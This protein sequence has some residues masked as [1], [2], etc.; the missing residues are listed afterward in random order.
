MSMTFVLS[1]AAYGY[2]FYKSDDIA[3]QRI[4]DFEE[5]SGMSYSE[6]RMKNVPQEEFSQ[7]Y[8]TLG[9]TIRLDRA[10]EEN[11]PQEA[12][13]QSQV[14]LCV[15]VYYQ[16]RSDFTSFEIWLCVYIPAS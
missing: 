13:G 8:V 10:A 5:R 6:F 9:L 7:E 14:I 3:A 4:Q 11:L 1:L 12:P 16:C 2:Y 15:F